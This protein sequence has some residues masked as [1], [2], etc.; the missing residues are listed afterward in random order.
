MFFK[1]FV[2]AL[3]LIISAT[4]IDKNQDN[5]A[6][7]TSID[8]AI[9]EFNQSKKIS[10]IGDS[11]LDSSIPIIFGLFFAWKA[12]KEIRL[13]KIIKTVGRRT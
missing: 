5:E 1:V 13:E 9:D 6:G 7:I 11:I 3:Y 8:K 10:R 2:I 12:K 4:A